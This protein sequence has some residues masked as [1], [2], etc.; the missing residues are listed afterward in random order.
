MRVF[1]PHIRLDAIYGSN[2]NFILQQIPHIG[3]LLASTFED[4]ANWADHL[5]VAQNPGAD[6]KLAI[7]QSSL[8]VLDLTGGNLSTQRVLQ[9]QPV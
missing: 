1:D 6:L 8:P 4:V 9:T 3:R 2:R 7:Q 5:V